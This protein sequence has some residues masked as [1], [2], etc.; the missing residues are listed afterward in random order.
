MIFVNLATVATRYEPEARLEALA[1]A[2]Q[3][4]APKVRARVFASGFARAC[5]R[6]EVGLEAML[7]G[8]RERLEADLTEAHL[9]GLWSLA[10]EPR[11]PVLEA[12]A[13]AGGI[14]LVADASPLLRAGF[15]AY[16]PEVDQVLGPGRF[17]CDLGALADE[18]HF[19][20]ALAAALP[21]AAPALLDRDPAQLA[22]AAAAGWRVRAL[23][24][25]ADL[26]AALVKL[27]RG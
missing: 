10:Y 6:G 19:Y 8:L 16:L 20:A 14:G 11:P 12:C 5:D 2:A 4:S 17:S 27:R 25:E 9:M 22:A 26:P 15:A 21:A 3:L 23:A 13:A 7:A 24:G 1:E 18:A